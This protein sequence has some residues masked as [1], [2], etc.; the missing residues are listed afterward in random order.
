MILFISRSTF[1]IVQHALSIRLFRMGESDYYLLDLHIY[2]C[3]LVRSYRADFAC[4][5]HDILH[6]IFTSLLL[7]NASFIAY[8]AWGRAIICMII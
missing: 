8:F 3:S 2:M 1:C 6:H 5:P 7:N 4:Y